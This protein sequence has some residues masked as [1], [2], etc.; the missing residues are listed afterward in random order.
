MRKSVAIALF[1]MLAGCAP[2]T[3][4]GLREQHAGKLVFEVDENYQSVYRK[5]I[6]P[7]RNCW[8]S[9]WIGSHTTAQGDLYTD[10]RSGSVSFTSVNALAGVSTYLTIDVK[11]LSENR[12]L[13]MSYYA[14]EGWKDSA[15]VVERWVKQNSMECK[16][17]T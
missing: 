15:K 7:A 14:L 8:Q 2:A 11:A 5:I 9:A 4:Q 1:V 16:M 3:V 10:T 6:T 17:P 12:T 13:V